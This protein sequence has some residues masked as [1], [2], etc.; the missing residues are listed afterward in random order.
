MISF[1][2]AVLIIRLGW[3]QIA[4]GRSIVPNGSRTVREQ[5]VV[6]RQEGVVV[7]TGRGHFT[8][9][10][11]H[12]ITGA[13]VQVP[14]LFP[15]GPA[16]QDDRVGRLA[17]VLHTD[18]SELLRR[19][20]SLGSPVVWKDSHGTPVE[21]T[22]QEA[23]HISRLAPGA[24]EVV[25]YRRRYDKSV[26]GMQWLGF[27]YERPGNSLSGAAG[28]EKTLEPLLKGEGATFISHLVDAERHTL[29]DTG[30]RISTPSNHHYPLQVQTTIDLAL[31]RKIENLTAH[32]PMKEGAV[33]V[34]D[35]GNADV[36]AMISRPFYD[37]YHVNPEG[38][39][40]SNRAVKA[41]VP[42][43]IFKIVTAAAAL[44]T[45]AARK[46]ETFHCRGEYGA[47]GLA[48]WKEEGHGRLNLEQGFAESCNTVFAKLAERLTS[49]QLAQMA[50]A[51]GL[52]REVGWAGKDLAGMKQLR[53]FD[54]EEAGRIFDSRT[55]AEDTGAR[56]QT[57]IGQR[58]VKVTPLQAANLI[59]SLL[60]NGEVRSPRLVR[61][62]QYADG[63]T[64]LE[65]PAH[66]LPASKGR[67]S[68]HTA[69]TILYWME[70]VV[71]EGTGKG[72]A[73][74]KWKLA[75]KSGTAQTGQAGRA[76][77]NQWFI[78]Y[79][80]VEQ[81]R[82]AVAVLVQ[83]VPANSSNQATALFGQVMDLL[84]SSEGGASPS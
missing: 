41:A 30:L 19:W 43:S 74:A 50:E 58:D 75:G 67:I 23:A 5:S 51:L 83:N 20:K 72:L 21:L 1:L 37:P 77:N 78:G 14:V 25:P 40:W 29:P 32:S 26:N 11:G 38:S 42:G 63:G 6:Q 62:I 33:V 47:Y 17:R 24:A 2:I 27:L 45:G 70:K 28:L 71:Q 54:G 34:L 79:G 48:C 59:V 3:L 53:L 10:S 69:R 66:A 61:R 13:W 81:P 18:A 73:S 36:L 76:V 15:G 46:G 44:E 35:A 60:H 12:S 57:A 68:P 31:Q 22:D 49:S 56:V 84:A 64:L 55:K 82:Y 8:D 52:G 39:D 7:D 9:R 65:L 16:K 80:P 4:A